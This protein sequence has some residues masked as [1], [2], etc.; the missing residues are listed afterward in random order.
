[1]RPVS[2]RSLA[3]FAAATCVFLAVHAAAQQRAPDLAGMWSD[4]PATPEDTFCFFSCSDAGLAR[5]KQLLDDPANDARPYTA[6]AA[7]A[8]REEMEKYLKPRLTQAALSTYPLDP[9]ADR[10]YLYCE[11]WGFAMQMF[12][13]HQLEITQ[14]PDRVELHYGEWDAHRTVY[15]DGKDR[16]EKRVPSPL[17]YSVGHYEGSTLVIETSGITANA[18]RWQFSHSDRLT[19]VERYARSADGARLELTATL[20]DPTSFTEP[21]VVKKIWS[22]A[23]D[24]EIYP[25]DSCEPAAKDAAAGKRP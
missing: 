13:P 4:P 17:G 9:L 24:Q 6:L 18:T 15:L 20:T 5:L 19:A 16:P 11:P 8:Q 21:L 10:G 2:F 14:L 23:P 25:Y 3:A 12:A 1:M 22:W 7:E